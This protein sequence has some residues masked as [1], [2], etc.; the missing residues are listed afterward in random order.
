M[1][2]GGGAPGMNGDLRIYP[3]SAYVVVVLANFDPL[4]ASGSTDYLDRG[5]D[6]VVARYLATRSTRGVAPAG[7]A[8]CNRLR[9]LIATPPSCETTFGTSGTDRVME[10]ASSDADCVARSL[11]EP[12]AFEPIFDRHFAAVHRH[13]HRRVGRD[14]ADELAAETFAVAFERRDL[15]RRVPFRGCTASRRTRLRRRWSGPSA[16]SCA[17]TLGRTQRGHLG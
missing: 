3:K 8:L 12:T 15:P 7:A 4:A 2:H 13:L 14:V 9:G 16:A 1:G 6:R 11:S 5:F 17:P 10:S